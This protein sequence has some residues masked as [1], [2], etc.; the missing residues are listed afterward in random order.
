MGVVVVGS[1][2]DVT[3]SI[4][5]DRAT[6]EQLD[7]EEHVNT[8]SVVRDLINAFLLRGDAVEVGLERRIEHERKK[9]ERLRLQR[10]QITTDIE[11]VEHE[12][13]TL[14]QLLSNR[15]RSTP[16]EVIEFVEGVNSGRFSAGQLDPDNEALKNWASKAGLPPERFISEVENRL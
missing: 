4:R 7:T 12:I 14:E 15:R 3:L 11:S 10:E 1:D 2:K 5:V 9:L 13:E 6:K 16:E 8:S